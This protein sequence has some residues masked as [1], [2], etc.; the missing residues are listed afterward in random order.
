MDKRRECRRLGRARVV[1]RRTA[2]A[3]SSEALPIGLATGGRHERRGGRFA[4][5]FAADR[6]AEAPRSDEYF[7]DCGL[8]GLE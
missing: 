6:A 4:R 2:R 7:I 8:G 5:R 3:R 1:Q